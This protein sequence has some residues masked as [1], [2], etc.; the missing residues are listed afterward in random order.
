MP[1]GG[2]YEL[3][4]LVDNGE[5]LWGWHFTTDAKGNFRLTGIPTGGNVVAGYTPS[6]T[7]TSRTQSTASGSAYGTGGYAYGS[8]YGTGTT[9]TTVPGRIDWAYQPGEWLGFVVRA[10]GFRPF[11]TMVNFPYPNGSY[12]V[13]RLVGRDVGSLDA[14]E[15]RIRLTLTPIPGDESLRGIASP[16]VVATP[17]PVTATRSPAAGL[18]SRELRVAVPVL[19]ADA[20]RESITEPSWR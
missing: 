2:I 11:V 20:D 16:A 5:S 13:V 7:Y 15:G 9:T 12:G 14:D 17:E 19:A 3:Q 18:P 10:P 1:Q 6:R 4:R 8:A